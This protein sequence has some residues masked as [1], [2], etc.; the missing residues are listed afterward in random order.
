MQ[1]VNP[2]DD[3]AVSLGVVEFTSVHSVKFGGPNDE[4]IH[5]HPLSGKGLSP[6]GAHRVVNSQWISQEEQINSVHSMHRGGW[7]DSL[8]HYLFCFH[9]S[10]FECLAEGVTAR[11][12]TAP[13]R[14][15]LHELTDQLLE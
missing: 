15:L 9:D 4:V 1:V 6:Y 13:L 5:G 7:H 12:H 10:M 3:H 14:D 8:N 2:A 11:Q